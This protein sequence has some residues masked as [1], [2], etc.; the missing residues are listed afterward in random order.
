MI[1]VSGACRQ[2]AQ[3]C[4]HLPEPAGGKK[5]G[6]DAWWDWAEGSVDARLVQELGKKGTLPLHPL[7]YP[8]TI[9]DSVSLYPFH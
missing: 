9:M 3:G 4:P 8:S 6:S 5:K 1:Q 7:Y 2:V